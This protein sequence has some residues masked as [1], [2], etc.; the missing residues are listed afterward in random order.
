MY[1]PRAEGLLPA[2][3]CVDG[4]YSFQVRHNEC[5]ATQDVMSHS[6]TS[7]QQIQSRAR[8]QGLTVAAKQRPSKMNEEHRLVAARY[9]RCDRIE[10]ETLMVALEDSLQIHT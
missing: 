3:S 10:H 9:L 6:R 8:S 5:Q 4:Q 2:P 1:L 7:T